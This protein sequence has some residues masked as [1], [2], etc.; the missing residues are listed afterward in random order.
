VLDTT[1][2][3]AHERQLLR[4]SLAAYL[5]SHVTDARTLAALQTEHGFDRAAWHALAQQ[6]QVTGLGIPEQFG[7]SGFGLPEI[8]TVCEETGRALLCVPY[9]STVVLA[10]SL[11]RRCTESDLAGGYLRAIAAGELVATVA[12]WEESLTWPAGPIRTRAV[13]HGDAWHVA[14]VHGFVLDGQVADLILVVAE[15]PQGLGLFAV[16]GDAPGLSRT[17]LATLDATRPQ[18]R[19]TFACPARLLAVGD[20]VEAHVR[21]ALDE[22]AVALAAEQLGGAR[23]VFG[24]TLDHVRNRTQFGRA[25]GSFQAVKHRC[26]DMLIAVESAQS[27]LW[28][29]VR[30]YSEEPGDFPVASCVALAACS[31]AFAMV[32]AETIHLHGG[33]GFAWE[34][35]AHLYFRRATSSQLLMG[36]PRYQREQLAARLAF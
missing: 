35:P 1:T 2:D 7:G 21:A 36:N 12:L 5:S 20:V 29:A 19:L 13:W 15:C 25:L 28:D 18:A 14:G 30:A 23:H 11:L 3:H 17:P 31:E 4:E 32:A 10:A 34:H 24:L 9:L 27:A 26:A 16:D 33:M 22:A 6:L 8:A